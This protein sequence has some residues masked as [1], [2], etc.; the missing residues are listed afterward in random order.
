MLHT[1]TTSENVCRI[2][3]AAANAST[4][5]MAT[6]PRT[7]SRLSPARGAAPPSAAASAGSAA[8]NR[9]SPSNLQRKR[10]PRWAAACAAAAAGRA[11][12]SRDSCARPVAAPAD[13]ASSAVRMRKGAPSAV[14]IR[15]QRTLRLSARYP[16]SRR[17]RSSR[18]W[19]AMGNVAARRRN[20]RAFGPSPDSRRLWKSARSS[21][22]TSASPKP[23]TAMARPRSSMI[24]IG[25]PAP[26]NC[27]ASASNALAAPGG[28]ALSSDSFD[29]G[30]TKVSSL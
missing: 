6:R 30:R 4:F 16:L 13:G 23:V 22:P 29:G 28:R 24:A 26:F 2:C 10:R 19:P 14:A 9:P 8:P 12:G 25:D 20:W 17:M 15:K 3:N 21:A 18:G 27:Q 1:T 7:V 11:A 5:S